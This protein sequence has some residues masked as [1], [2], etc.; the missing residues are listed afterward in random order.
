MKIQ[1]RISF[2]ILLFLLL[3]HLNIQ[4]QQ[5][6][7]AAYNILLPNKDG[8]ILSLDKNVGKYV[9]LHFWAS[10]C[11]QSL[12][13]MASLNDIY[14][15]YQAASF[16]DAEGFEIYSVSLDS[17]KNE[18]LNKLGSNG[19]IWP[20]QVCDFKSYASPVCRQYQVTNT[21]TSFLISSNG[22]II[23]QNIR[24]KELEAF[25]A[26]QQSKAHYGSSRNEL[27]QTFSQNANNPTYKIQLGV[28]KYP[29]LQ[30]FAHIQH[31][32]KLET[33]TTPEG[34]TRI[35]LGSFG[36]EAETNAVLGQ[37]KGQENCGKAFVL[38][39]PNDILPAA[40]EQKNDFWANAQNYNTGI[41]PSVELKKADE[42]TFYDQEF[43]AL[44]SKP[45]VEK[46]PETIVPDF[47]ISDD[48]FSKQDNR[49]VKVTIYAPKEQ[50]P[51]IRVIERVQNEPTPQIAINSNAN[52]SPNQSNK[53]KT[54]TSKPAA[55]PSFVAKPVEIKTSLSR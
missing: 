32:G 23:A 47:G 42:S 54:A 17:D 53:T 13:E 48:V 20:Q 36:S 46:V 45:I 37:V 40:N 5:Q 27:I 18:W 39:V 41:T 44:M 3:P 11:P 16:S 2:F 4:S 1:Y 31:L 49:Q 12:I 14:A 43:K 19:L 29:N 26:E 51:S 8:T 15:H 50:P 28:F 35:T 22:T 10:W 55:A 25:L 21:P 30:K 52:Y 34:Y 33:E 7:S 24:P 9:Y 6:N 38:A